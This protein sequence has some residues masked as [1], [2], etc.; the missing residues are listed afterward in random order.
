MHADLGASLVGR[1]NL[2]VQS[3]P[4]FA[5]QLTVE[6]CGR[7]TSRDEAL[8]LVVDTEPSLATENKPQKDNFCHS[9]SQAARIIPGLGCDG[10]R[11]SFASQHSA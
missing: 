4:R 11:S 8:L 5:L 9:P 1:H 10:F 7:S 2:L 3:Q 6:G